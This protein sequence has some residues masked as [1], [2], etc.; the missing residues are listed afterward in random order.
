M[1]SGR[2][3]SED[4]RRHSLSLA[5]S[6]SARRCPRYSSS[7]KAGSLCRNPL[8]SQ[9]VTGNWTQTAR[10]YYRQTA[11]LRGS[12]T[13]GDV[14]RRS[15]TASLFEQPG[16]ELASTNPRAGAAHATV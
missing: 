9:A 1:A 8:V 15:S 7:T 14:G 5:S 13:S 3:I 16:G 12:E 11:E 2:G 6:R 4:Q 10:H